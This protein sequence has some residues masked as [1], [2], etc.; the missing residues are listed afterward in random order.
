M[1]TQIQGGAYFIIQERKMP[2]LLTTPHIEPAVHDQPEET[3]VFVQLVDFRV[4]VTEA[5]TVLVTQYGNV[6]DGSW[7]PGRIPVRRFVVRDTP[8]ETG[9]GVDPAD[10]EQKVMEV[11]P[12]STA[13]T[14]LVAALMV[15]QGDVGKNY[16][17]ALG[18]HLLQWLID[19][20]YYVGVVL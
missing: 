16:L 5:T 14:E 17:A 11:V 10:G 19:Q 13:F 7:V 9:L 6:V 1:M 4:K 8:A 3:Y 15:A 18:G 12:A 20:G 2:I